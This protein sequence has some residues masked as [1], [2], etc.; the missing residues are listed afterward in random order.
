MKSIRGKLIFHQIAG[1]LAMYGIAGCIYSL[2]VE[3]LLE[4]RFDDDLLTWA[5]TISELFDFEDK[6]IDSHFQNTFFD[7]QPFEQDIRYYQIRNHKGKTVARSLSLKGMDLPRIE[8]GTDAHQFEDIELPGGIK[9]RAVAF[10]YINCRPHEDLDG[11]PGEENTGNSGCNRLFIIMACSREW[12]DNIL[13]INLIALVGTGILLSLGSI[14]I[15]PGIIKSGLSPLNQIAEKA[16]SIEITNLG[17]SFPTIHLPKE[18]QPITQRLNDLLERLDKAFLRER[19]FTSDVAHELRT[20][21]A[22]LRALAEVGLAMN[23]DQPENPHPYFKDALEIAFQMQNLTDSLLGLARADAGNLPVKAE[24]IDLADLL[25][26]TWHK[27]K[28]KAQKRNITCSLS[29]PGNRSLVMADKT[30][31]TAIMTNL[32]S[33]AVSHAPENARVTMSITKEKADLQVSISNPVDTLETKDLEYIFQPLW[34]KDSARSDHSHSGIGLALVKSYSSLLNFSVHGS[35]PDPHAFEIT[36]TLPGHCHG[37]ASLK[38][39]VS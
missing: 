24:K 35:M 23:P 14:V 27:F 32:I 21:I 34:R 36:L 9:G 6:E 15:L 13:R 19:R 29:T 22:E 37:P 26:E 2:T 30:M 11:D 38:K 18:L 28:K 7:R 3:A 16:A 17:Q 25:G 39:S 31:M 33:N 10:S 1:L 4:N 12:I 20:P 8:A 5:E